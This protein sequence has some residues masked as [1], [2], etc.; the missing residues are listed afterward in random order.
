MI[1]LTFLSDQNGCQYVDITSGITTLELTL[2][3]RISAIPREV[4]LK[5]KGVHTAK[6][7]TMLD[8]V[9]PGISRI[10]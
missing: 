2:F 9:I 5:N 10:W 4:F 1:S 8:A 6:M 3:A 7:L